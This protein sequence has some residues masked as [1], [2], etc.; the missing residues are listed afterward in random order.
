MNRIIDRI[1]DLLV[2]LLIIAFL[3]VSGCCWTA[4]FYDTEKL[5]SFQERQIHSDQEWIISCSDT[6]KFRDEYY[7]HKN[8]KLERKLASSQKANKELEEKLFYYHQIL[9]A[10][11]EGSN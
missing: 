8:L 7:G 6:I 2:A 3:A 4:Y 9:S 5:I 11:I 10:V 1:I